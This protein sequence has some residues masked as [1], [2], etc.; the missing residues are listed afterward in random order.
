MNARALD[1]PTLRAA[2]WTHRTL[3]RV[4]DELRANGLKYSAAPAPPRLP[5]HARRGVLAVLRRQRSTCLERAL[6]LQRW[7]QAH[8]NGRDVVIAV[9]NARFD[10]AAHAWLD[11]EPDG[12]VEAFAELLR[13]PPR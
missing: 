2:W 12:D 10:F 11:G 13:L 4:H 3:R 6:V 1:V 8:G 5:Q 9:K 7:H